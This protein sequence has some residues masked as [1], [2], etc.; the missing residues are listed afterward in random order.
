MSFSKICEN[1][2]HLSPVT[3]EFLFTIIFNNLIRPNNSNVSENEIMRQNNEA[4]CV[5]YDA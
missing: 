3:L 2:K 5:V 1:I 4:F